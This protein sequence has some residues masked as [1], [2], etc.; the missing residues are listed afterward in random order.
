VAEKVTVTLPLVEEKKLYTE[1]QLAKIISE[2]VEHP[3]DDLEVPAYLRKQ[4][5]VNSNS[6]E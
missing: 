3:G 4:E 2:N 6:A 5:T 1:P